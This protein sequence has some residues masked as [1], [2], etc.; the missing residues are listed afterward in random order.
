MVRIFFALLISSLCLF[1]SANKAGSIELVLD[2]YDIL[3]GAIGVKIKN[4]LYDVKFEEKNSNDLFMTNGN[5]Y[6]FLFTTLEE[7]KEASQALLDQVLVDKYDSHPEYTHGIACT[8]YSYILTPFKAEFSNDDKKILI[9]FFSAYNS[10]NQIPT[11]DYAVQYSAQLASWSPTTLTPDSLVCA[12]WTLN[13]ATT[14][15]EPATALIFSVGILGIAN[16][17]RKQR[18]VKA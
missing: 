16:F 9:Y 5:N 13:P 2:E 18:T 8:S 6:N 12:V 4:K 3:L 15:P 14:V 17:G 11:E 7:A 10:D 1:F